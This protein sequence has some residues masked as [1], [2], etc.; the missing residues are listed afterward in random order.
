MKT[1]PP[2]GLSKGHDW[3]KLVQP[4]FLQCSFPQKRLC[5]RMVRKRRVKPK[6]GKASSRPPRR[7]FCSQRHTAHTS[8]IAP[9]Q[10][11]AAHFATT[12]YNWWWFMVMGLVSFVCVFFI[13]HICNFSTWDLFLGEIRFV[14]VRKIYETTV[15]RPGLL[16][17][18]LLVLPARDP[19][20][21]SWDPISGKTNWCEGS[22]L[23]M[24]THLAKIVTHFFKQKKMTLSE[25]T[26]DIIFWKANFELTQLR[27]LHF[28]CFARLDH[29]QKNM[30]NCKTFF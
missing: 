11:W 16:H 13:Y 9:K 1:W 12:N 7:R 24:N 30:E 22:D 23:A 15:S 26:S 19:F 18:V 28:F 3:K 27:H 2:F 20:L 14:F 4:I 10:E 21:G 6:S 25:S 8:H 5:S 17:P 29:L